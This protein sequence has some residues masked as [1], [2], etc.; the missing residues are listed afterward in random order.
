MNPE[1][2]AR[3]TLAALGALLFVSAVM[4][5]AAFVSELFGLVVYWTGV[6]CIPGFLACALSCVKISLRE[7][8]RIFLPASLYGFLMP[9]MCWRERSLSDSVYLLI[10]CLFLGF[11]SL[12]LSAQTLNIL[13]CNSPH[14]WHRWL[15]HLMLYGIFVPFAAYLI[16]AFLL[17]KGESSAE[18]FSSV[19]WRGWG[20]FVL[21]GRIANC[22]QVAGMLLAALCCFCIKP[23]LKV[24]EQ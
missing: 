18:I 1:I 17:V 23:V 7:W 22:F 19:L 3:M 15:R 13:R 12:W 14:R 9:L 8:D 5:L 10:C 4:Q 21:D 6:V 11:V 16:V 2:K 20:V 24:E